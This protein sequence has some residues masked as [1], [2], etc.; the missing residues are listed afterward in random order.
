M[1]IYR[2]EII[3]YIIDPVKG[4]NGS[5]ENTIGEDG[6]VHYTS[7]LNFEE[8]RKEKGN[9]NLIVIDSGRLEKEIEKFKR[10]QMKVFEEISHEEFYRLYEVL[11]PKRIFK[12]DGAFSFFVGEPWNMTLYTFCFKSGDK[13]YKGIRDIL[14]KDGE[15]GRDITIHLKYY[16][17]SYE[18]LEKMT[19]DYLYANRN[20]GG[21]SEFDLS[22]N[23]ISRAVIY[24]YYEKYG[25]CFLGKYNLYDEDRKNLKAE[26]ISYN[27]QPIYN[28]EFAFVVPCND[29]KHVGLIREHNRKKE[30]FNSHDIMKG[31]EKITDRITELKGTGLVWA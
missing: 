9:E 10:S 31:I 21:T 19:T 3:A 6:I 7:E 28:F 1:P 2:K 23:D 16:I 17:R 25:E 4:F 18:E 30:S 8:Y 15:L 26:L 22:I 20:T 29:E 14:M 12:R 5:V 11:P 13:Y 27:G 24:K